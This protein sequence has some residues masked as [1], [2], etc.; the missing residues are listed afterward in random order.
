MTPVDI[1]PVSLLLS[2]AL[3]QFRQADIPGFI[4]RLAGIDSQRVGDKALAQNR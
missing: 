1:F 3:K 2:N 4:S